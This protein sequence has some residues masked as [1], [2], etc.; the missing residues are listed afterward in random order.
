VVTEVNGIQLDGPTQGLR[1]LNTLT[2]ATQISAT[3]ER[4]GEVIQ[5]SYS[6]Q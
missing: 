4:G 2:Q 1:A 6:L 3:V 5:V